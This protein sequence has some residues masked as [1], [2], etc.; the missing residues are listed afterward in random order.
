MGHIWVEIISTTQTRIGQQ[1]A[2]RLPPLVLC[3]PTDNQEQ[4]PSNLCMPTEIVLIIT[5][6]LHTPL[7]Q[8]LTSLPCVPYRITKLL[9]PYHSREKPMV[10]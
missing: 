4:L 2:T 7:V 3:M 6:P 5:T 1:N 10:Y 8:P 9:F